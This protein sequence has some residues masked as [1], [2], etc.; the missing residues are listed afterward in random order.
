MRLDLPQGPSGRC[1]EDKKL[2]LPEIE[3]G[4]SSPSLSLYLLSYPDCFLG[5]FLI[6][7]VGGGVQLSALGTEATNWP[8]VPAPGDYDDGEIGGMMIGRGNRSAP[9]KPA[10]VPLCPP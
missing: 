4:P 1:G 7:T 5:V 8:L 10:P 9:R 2:A 6:G 3:P